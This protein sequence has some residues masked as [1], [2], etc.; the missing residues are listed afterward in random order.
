MPHSLSMMRVPSEE[1]L[2]KSGR[3]YESYAEEL[4]DRFEVMHSVFRDA[5]IKA[6]VDLTYKHALS[7]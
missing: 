2:A 1:E 6:A 7:R 3:D 5:R 4:T